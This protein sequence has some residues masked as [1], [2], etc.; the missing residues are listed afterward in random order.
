MISLSWGNYY[1]LNDNV[2]DKYIIMPIKLNL[3]NI[4]SNF[5]YF[6]KSEKTFEFFRMVELIMVHW[7]VY[8]D[9]FLNGVGQNWMSADVAYALAIQLLDIEEETCDYAIKDV[10]TFV[11]IAD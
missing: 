11:H 3:P 8:F 7:N 6:K 1:S 2:F 9:K 4:Y 5:T 10:P